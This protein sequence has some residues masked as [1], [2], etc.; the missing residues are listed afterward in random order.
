MTGTMQNDKFSSLDHGL[1]DWPQISIPIGLKIFGIAAS[2]LGLL[3][4]VAYNSHQR[5][6]QLQREV[7]DL[8]EYIIPITNRVDEVDTRALEQEVHLERILKL[9]EEKSLDVERI[10]QEQ[11]QF[12]QQEG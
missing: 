3:I 6:R 8:S 12:E 4:L 9:Y 7:F 1:Q 10:V 11:Q 5:L 2:L